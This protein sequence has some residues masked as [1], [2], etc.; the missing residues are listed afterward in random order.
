M[1]I[2]N[3]LNNMGLES[4]TV[5]TNAEQ[6]YSDLQSYTSMIQN[7]QMSTAISTQTSQVT[8]EQPSGKDCRDNNHNTI[9]V[10]IFEGLCPSQFSFSLN[11]TSIV[12]G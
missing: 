10:R 6:I 4:Y 5:V 7:S 9:F 1:L 2:N 11:N 8:H 12:I 3:K